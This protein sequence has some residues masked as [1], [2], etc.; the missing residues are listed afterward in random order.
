[1]AR[2]R[3]TDVE[4]IRIQLE[5]IDAKL[6]AHLA[7]EEVL[8]E[9]LDKHAERISESLE[10]IGNTLVAQQSALAEQS[11]R[12]EH[13]EQ[14]LA[15]EKLDIRA[16]VKPLLDNHQKV[17]G[18]FEYSKPAFKALLVIAGIAG[19]GVGIEKLLAFL[20]KL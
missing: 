19:G 11:R 5:R 15:A 8:N 7:R 10:R 13:L 12:T 9:R 17:T 16:E 3:S 2:K 14:A 4:D 20:G 1:M 6:E 18:F